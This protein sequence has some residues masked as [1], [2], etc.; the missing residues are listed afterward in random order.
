MMHG[1]PMAGAAAASSRGVG[2]RRA[3]LAPRIH[4]GPRAL[5]PGM[6]VMTVTDVRAKWNRRYE[7]KLAAGSGPEPNP[8]ALRFAHRV[9]G[10]VLLDAACGLGTG[11][12]ALLG[13]V[14]R[15]VAVDLSETALR[16][17][18]AHFGADPRIQWIQADVSR[19][20]WPRDCFAVVCAFGFT[21]W[22]FLRQA[23]RILRPGGLMLYQGFSRRQLGCRPELD[24]AWTSTP[25]AIAALFPRWQVLACE[26]SGE[27]PYRVSFAAQRP[28]SPRRTVA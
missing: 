18:R 17:A 11:V 19:L 5:H 1:L 16:A 4:R 24:P 9:H 21:D 26:E 25:A 15:A 28:A 23:P 12:A 20:A 27:P 10:G 22:D 8:L 13:R 14:E 7:E 3:L 6:I 2:R